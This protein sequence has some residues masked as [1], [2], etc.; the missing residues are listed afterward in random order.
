MRADKNLYSFYSSTKNSLQQNPKTTDGPRTDVR[1][2]VGHINPQGSRLVMLWTGRSGVQIRVG[3]TDFCLLKKKKWTTFGVKRPGRDFSPSSA[4]DKNRWIYSSCY[5]LSWHGVRQLHIFRILQIRTALTQIMTPCLTDH[6]C[7]NGDASD[8]HS[9]T[10]FSGISQ[11]TKYRPTDTQIV[12][13][14]A[15]SGKVRPTTLKQTTT[16]SCYNFH[17]SHSI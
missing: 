11:N 10:L 13:C 9:R 17:N 16:A 1:G 5:V 2:P 7:P 12:A 15:H 3:A 4:E 8:G 6:V 14:S